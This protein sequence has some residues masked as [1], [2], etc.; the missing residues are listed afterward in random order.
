MFKPVV[1]IPSLA[2]PAGP[3]FAA[4][5]APNAQQSATQPFRVR[6]NTTRSAPALAYGSPKN[7]FRVSRCAGCSAA[8]RSRRPFLRRIRTAARSAMAPADTRRLACSVS[9]QD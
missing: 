5:T 3:V 4:D 7:N 1:R 8:P 2:L 6:Q 9:L